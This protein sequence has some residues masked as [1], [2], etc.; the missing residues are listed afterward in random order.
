MKSAFN[1]FFLISVVFQLQAYSAEY[2]LKLK[3]TGALS[4]EYLAT[5]FF[6]TN[7]SVKKLDY[8]P[9]AQ[10][11]RVEIKGL[12]Q[13]EALRITA[14]EQIEFLTPN[15]KIQI[16]KNNAVPVSR[17]NISTGSQ[18]QWNLEKVHATEAWALA[19]NRGSSKIVVAVIDSGIDSSH[20]DLKANI[21]PG[22]NFFDNNT[23]TSDKFGHGTHCAGI[24]G[25]RGAGVYG[26]SPDVSLMPLKFLNERGLGSFYDGI[27]AIDY[28][29]EKKVDIISA[30]WGAE[31]SKPELAQVLKKAGERA[32]QAGIVLVAA[33]GNLNRDNDARP[34]FPANANTPSILSV[35]GTDSADIKMKISN[36][37]TNNVKIAAPGID[38]LSTAPGNKYVLMSGTSMATPLVAGLAALIKAQKPQ[39]SASQIRDIIVNNGAPAH[40]ENI[41]HC[42]IDAESSMRFTLEHF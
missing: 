41:C 16:E 18:K 39:L 9:H 38:I 37:G 15:Q 35:A 40:V 7:I 21:I 23:D 6:N 32:D 4:S 42:R 10:L 17:A 27:R 12:R 26:L 13:A 28:A 1:L 34:Y 36:F 30:S 14:S 2:I 5:A 8:N 25:A 20:P 19:G 22:Y 31:I 24:V 3:N 11:F 29:I 33:A